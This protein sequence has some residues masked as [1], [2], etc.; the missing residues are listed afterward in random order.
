MRKS[1]ASEISKPTPKQS[2]GSRRSPAWSSAPAPR[3]SRRAS[4]R[5]SGVASMKPL[6]L[7]PLE[8]CSPTAR[9]T[10][11]RTRASSSSASN[12]RRSWSRC[13]IDTMLNGGR[14][15]MMSAR[16]RAASISTR[17]PSSAARRGSV[18]VMV[19]MRRFPCSTQLVFA[20]DQLAAQQLAD[21]RFRD[22][23]DE[24]IAARPL[25][26]GEA[27]CAAVLVEI[28]VRDRGAAL[29]ERGDDLAPALVGR[30]TTATSATA[31][32]SDRQLRSRPA[33]RSRRR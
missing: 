25:E 11:T 28:V 15:R 7:P 16:S 29:H 32:C 6:M 2:R 8:K 3:C 14:S 24:H 5:V 4:T 33:R 23:L 9:S 12:T 26:V 13:G 19:V 18:K 17:K 30:P 10:I 1:Q 27:G 20:R 31:G 21:R 22:G